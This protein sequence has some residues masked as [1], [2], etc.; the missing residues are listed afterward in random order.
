MCDKVLVA[1]NPYQHLIILTFLLLVS[2]SVQWYPW[3]F[4]LD[5]SD[6]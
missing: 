2:M 4:S 6:D 5:F 3:G 1:P